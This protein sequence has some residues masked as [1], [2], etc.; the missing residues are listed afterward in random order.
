[1]PNVPL[2]IVDPARKY[3]VGDENDTNAVRDFFDALEDFAVEKN[4]AV[5]VVH[6]LQRGTTPK[7]SNDILD[8]LSGSQVFA[9]RPRVVIGMYRYNSH[10]A[11]GLAKNNIPPNFGMVTDER[12]FA[13]K[14]ENLSLIWLP[15]KEEAR[16]TTG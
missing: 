15:G 3:I 11:V 10:I 16:N 8:M 6:H 14:Q 1:M 13:R 12:V 9:D 4:S 2:L 5:I 7:N